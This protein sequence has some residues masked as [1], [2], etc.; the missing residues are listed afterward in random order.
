MTTNVFQ[1]WN[2][3]CSAPLTIVPSAEEAALNLREWVS[4][5]SRAWHSLTILTGRYCSV[6]MVRDIHRRVR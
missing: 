3:G 1:G 2:R 5:S 4:R 6:A